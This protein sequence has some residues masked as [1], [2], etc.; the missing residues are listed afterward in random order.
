MTE[1]PPD[2]EENTTYETLEEKKHNAAT[3]ISPTSIAASI[4]SGTA[5]AT[6]RATTRASPQAPSASP[7]RGENAKQNDTPEEKSRPSELSLGP[8]KQAIAVPVLSVRLKL[9]AL[10]EAK[11]EAERLA[12]EKL[13]VEE[14]AEATK[15]R[16]AGASYL[17]PLKRVPREKTLAEPVSKQAKVGN[18]KTSSSPERVKTAA[19]GDVYSRRGGRRRRATPR[20]PDSASGAAS[21][22]RG[23]ASNLDRRSPRVDISSLL[24]HG[25]RGRSAPGGTTSPRDASNRRATD[26]DARIA[27]YTDGPSGKT[28]SHARR[29]GDTDRAA[30]SKLRSPPRWAATTM[31]RVQTANNG[32]HHVR[33]GG[34]RERGTNNV[35]NSSG[36]RFLSRPRWGSNTPSS[37]WAAFV[38]EKRG[39]GGRDNGGRG[40]GT[41]N[42]ISTNRL[43]Q[44]PPKLTK[45]GCVEQSGSSWSSQRGEASRGR[46]VRD[47]KGALARIPPSRRVHISLPGRRG[48]TAKADRA[49]ASRRYKSPRRARSPCAVKKRTAS[50]SHKKASPCHRRTREKARDGS[51]RNVGAGDRINNQGRYSYGGDNPTSLPQRTRE[52]RRTSRSHVRPAQADNVISAFLVEASGSKGGV[53]GE[54]E[55]GGVSRL[56]RTREGAA[57]R[58]GTATTR[59]WSDPK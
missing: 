45:F 31:S 13:A 2:A 4:N 30:K 25:T 23:V 35:N 27:G 51:S 44:T 32:N 34:G 28:S 59:F 39:G 49:T 41:D 37:A 53:K 54:G 21:G 57:A 14:A 7:T 3:P 33:A 9:R 18:N 11:L 40:V 29:G 46:E 8:A 36:S 42:H 26:G 6:S 15:A 5:T 43:P 50:P 10:E 22:G 47:C 20:R 17:S 24:R 19:R 56:S 1:H 52:T 38:G 12:A 55:G 48:T 58:P 16:R